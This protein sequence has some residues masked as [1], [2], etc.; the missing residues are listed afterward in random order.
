[1]TVTT[2][3]VIG[4]GVRAASAKAMGLQEEWC[5][6]LAILGM[7][8]G[9]APDA[10][11]WLAWFLFKR[12]RWELYSRMHAGNLRWLG[13]IFW[14]CAAHLIWDKPFHKNSGEEWWPRLWWLEVFGLAFG[15][16]LLGWTFA[17]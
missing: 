14:G 9:M 8:E 10:L 12:P 2:H 5:V 15:I 1:M 7:V 4:A 13:V 6:W 16:A 11:D 3:G 17:P